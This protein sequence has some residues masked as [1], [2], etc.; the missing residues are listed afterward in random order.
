MAKKTETAELP[1]LLDSHALATL[2]GSSPASIRN[3]HARG[4]IP[5]GAHVPG[6]R[7]LRWRKADIAAWLNQQL[8]SAQ[9]AR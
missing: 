5:P 1:E 6:V 3:S 8:P 2:L 7:G 4:R 9:G